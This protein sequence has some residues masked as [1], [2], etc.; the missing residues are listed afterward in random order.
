MPEVNVARLDPA[1][2]QIHITRFVDQLPPVQ[3][4]DLADKGV[5]GATIA[6][7]SSGFNSKTLAKQLGELLQTEIPLDFGSLTPAEFVGLFGVTAETL[8]P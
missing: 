4:H 7:L 6:D 1:G 8:T 3:F 2:Q 5:A